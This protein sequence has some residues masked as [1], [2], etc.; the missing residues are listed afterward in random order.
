MDLSTPQRFNKRFR[1]RNSS[2]DEPSH[3][4]IRARD[5]NNVDNVN[6][7]SVDENEDFD[8]FNNEAMENPDPNLGA[9][10]G[11]SGAID[12]HSQVKD[13]I[14]VL[15]GELFTGTVNY[16]EAKIKIFKDG[17]GLDVGLLEREIRK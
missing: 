7:E 9:P 8:I 16:S 1:E 12:D 14:T 17:L 3:S 11:P 2:R 4:K 6:N 15:N 10:G 5:E 13:T